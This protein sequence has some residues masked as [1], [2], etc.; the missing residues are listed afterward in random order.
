LGACQ[1]IEKKSVEDQLLDMEKKLDLII[2]A[3]GL[4]GKHCLAPAEAEQIANNIVLE[5]KKK[6]A[7]KE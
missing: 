6:R 2:D 4:S 5:Y 1:H 7:K 3:M